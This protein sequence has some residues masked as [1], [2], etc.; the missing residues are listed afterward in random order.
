MC[1]QN[2]SNKPVSVE[3][4]RGG[5]AASTTHAHKRN[6]LADITLFKRLQIF[7]DHGECSIHD[8]IDLLFV[9]IY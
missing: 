3:V 6:V 4:L 9:I 8:K 5:A 1:T 2:N 7:F